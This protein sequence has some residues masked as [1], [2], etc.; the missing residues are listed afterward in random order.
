MGDLTVI[1][2][3]LDEAGAEAMLGIWRAFGGYG[4]Y[5]HEG[6]E[7]NF[8]PELAHRYDAAVNFIRTGGRFGRREESAELLL[9]RTN[10]FRETYAYGDEVVAPGIEPFRDHERLT[11]AARA[12][13]GRPVVVPSIVYAN[14][15]VPGQ[16]LAVHTDVPEFRGAS[17]KT[18]PE[19][20]LVVMHHS[21]MFD[22][23]RMPIATGIAYFGGGEG[24][25]LAYYPDGPAAPAR[26]YAP[27]HN[28]AALLDTDSTFHGVDRVGGDDS[29]VVAIRPGMRLHYD[30]GERWLVRDDGNVVAGYATGELRLSVSWKAY[31]FAD[32]AQRE[33][34]RSHGDDLALPTILGRLE[35]DLRRRGRLEGERPPD[36]E[37]GKLLIDEY[38]RF[39]APVAPA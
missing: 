5:S 18:F 34:W 27:R 23:W 10:Y 15:L 6:F 11:E 31:C 39:P 1:D 36:A 16:E 24:G 32:E 7:P 33:A 26:T 13:Y 4:Q 12:L 17:R 29:Q 30:G 25:E 8:A 20:L 22:A 14:V 9:A 21:S 3:L 38:V 35:D 28:T 19:W 2:P 37:F